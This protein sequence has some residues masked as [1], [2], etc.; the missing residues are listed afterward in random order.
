MYSTNTFHSHFSAKPSSVASASIFTS[1]P[2]NCARQND[3][4]L[5][6]LMH[7]KDSTCAVTASI[8]LS[9]CSR[10]H[11]MSALTADREIGRELA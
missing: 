1:Q 8:E 6:S 10:F 4:S 5:K 7:A 2:V 3:T 9:H 11:V